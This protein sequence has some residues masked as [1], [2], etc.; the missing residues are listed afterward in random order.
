LTILYP[1][2]REKSSVLQ[3]FLKK[4]C[5]KFSIEIWFICTKNREK[6]LKTDAKKGQGG[7]VGEIERFWREYFLDDRSADD[8][9]HAYGCKKEKRLKK[10]VAPLPFW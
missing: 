7:E 8:I 9:E 6:D 2:P 5:T 10:C 4:Y 3:N 1:H